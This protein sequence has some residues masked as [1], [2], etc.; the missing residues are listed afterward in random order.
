MVDTTTGDIERVRA[1]KQNVLA[2]VSCVL[3]RANGADIDPK[4]AFAA[5]R[6]LCD[7]L[8]GYSERPAPSVPKLFWETPLG[9]AVGICHGEPNEKE[10][11]VRT[12]LHLPQAVH[13]Q[14]SREADETGR[15]FAE[16]LA[17][18]LA[19]SLRNKAN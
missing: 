13:E 18:M 14:L 19:T 12:T 10:P 16:L 15:P 3:A 2:D 7:I 11:K 9:R 1:I 5:A 4:V 6:N 8:F 17:D